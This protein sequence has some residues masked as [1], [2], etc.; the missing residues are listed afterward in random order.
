MTDWILLVVSAIVAAA[1]PELAIGASAG[2]LYYLFSSKA[3]S[4]VRK[5][6]FMAI[7][8]LIGYSLGTPFVEG[9]WA[10]LI[11]IM[12]SAFAVAVMLQISNS[13]DEGQ[14]LPPVLLWLSDIYHKFRKN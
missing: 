8:W 1:V 13:L 11:S 6:A 5:I 10:M 12:G 3:E 2:S 9:G 14:G 4:T 7:G